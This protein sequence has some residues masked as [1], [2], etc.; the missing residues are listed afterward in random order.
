MFCAEVFLVSVGFYLFV[1]GFFFFLITITVT[2]FALIG[3]IY[4]YASVFINKNFT[5]LKAYVI[6][7]TTKKVSV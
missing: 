7:E 3:N 4:T 1:L 2:F 5:E 6:I